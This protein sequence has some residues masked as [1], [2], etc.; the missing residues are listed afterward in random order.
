MVTVNGHRL[1][2]QSSGTGSPA[3]IFEAAIMDFSPTWA[4]VQPGV[5]AFTRAVAYDRAGLGWSDP[6]D[7]PRDGENMVAELR[8]LLQKAGIP[9]PYVLVGQSF[10]GLLCR[11]YAYLHPEEVAGLVLLDPAHEDQFTRFPQPIQEM[12]SPIKEMQIQQLRAARELAAAGNLDQIPALV[13]IPAALPSELSQAYAHMSKASPDR[14]DTMIAE[15]EALETTQE[16][17]RAA[18]KRG[19]GNIPL[20]VISHGIPQAVPGVA[21]E[22]NAAYE[23][24]WQQMQ[25]EIAALSTTGM[26]LVAER[27]GHMI[28]HD[29]PELVIETISQ[30]VEM[31]RGL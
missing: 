16:Q 27:S 22:V 26:R 4:L 11:L 7:R 9:A 21:E 14:F 20:F 24:S 30:A 18:R 15:L 25:A 2:L 23:A 6:G 28:Q 8:L 19:L 29:Q 17:V 3:V 31:A 12:F 13:P 10:S 1:H 5:A